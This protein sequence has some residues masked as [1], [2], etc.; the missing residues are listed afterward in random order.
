MSRMR[1]LLA[2]TAI[3]AA[4]T[5]AALTYAF[6]AT[7]R[8]PV[9]PSPPHQFSPPPE[10][11]S[12][13]KLLIPNINL[14]FLPDPDVRSAQCDY[15]PLYECIVNG[16]GGC[17]ALE[18]DLRN[19]LDRVREPEPA[20]VGTTQCDY[21]PLWECIVNGNGGCEV[22]EKDLRNCLERSQK[23]N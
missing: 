18:Q 20:R 23:E 22:L 1:G 3:A 9:P 21:A 13:S 2:T 11:P 6:L 8:P 5:G 4:T 15:G 12:S 19:C 16:N 14:A 10:L 17:E 7:A